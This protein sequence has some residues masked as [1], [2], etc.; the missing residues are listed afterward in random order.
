SVKTW[1]M[2]TGA[3]IATL[4]GHS[5]GG[6]AVAISP[7]GR[8]IASGSDDATIRVWPVKDGKPDADRD[9]LVL[10][11]HKKAVTCLAF[12]A[13][14]KALLSGSQDNSLKLWNWDKEKAV[15]TMP[16]HKNWITSITLLDD[17]TALTTSDDLT[18]CLWDIATG[19][20]LGRIDFGAV[21]DC[22]R[23]ATRLGA[24]RILVGTSSWLIYEFQIL[25]S[26][27]G[28]SSK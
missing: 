22:P 13:D 9:T 2:P 19:N 6:N 28:G 4:T 3:E 16:V 21:G 20:E 26:K 5:E 25:K 12:T 15:R 10:E 24:D 8:W 14:G 18:I 27:A 17:G 1:F 7:D 23:C 11:G